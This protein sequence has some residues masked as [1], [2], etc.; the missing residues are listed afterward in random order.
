MK[1]YS[2]SKEV[3][4]ILKEEELKPKDIQ[5]IFNQVAKVN[6]KARKLQEIGTKWNNLNPSLLKSL[7]NEY[8][9]YTIN[10]KTGEI[11]DTNKNREGEKEND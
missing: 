6:W 9:S 1:D 8:N 3:K 5:F 4:K 10:I 2:R 11:I 7:L